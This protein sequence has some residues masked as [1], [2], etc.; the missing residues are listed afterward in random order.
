MAKKKKKEEFDAS[1]MGKYLPGIS[2]PVEVNPVG[3]IE[4]ALTVPFWQNRWRY[5]SGDPYEPIAYEYDIPKSVQI[6]D[7]WNKY[8]FGAGPY[9]I[10]AQTPQAYGLYRAGLYPTFRIALA[11]EFG[12]ATTI[13]ATFYTIMDPN[14]YW[15][16]PFT[17]TLDP[18]PTLEQARAREPDIWN[19]GMAP[20]EWIRSGST[21]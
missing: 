2:M 4:K 15:R 14:R 17:S 6:L 18:F 8:A 1:L 19:P 11:F 13:M 10:I 12:V 20:G 7:A 16:A 5:G 3:G 21:V 9:Q